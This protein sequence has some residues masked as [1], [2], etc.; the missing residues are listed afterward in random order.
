MSD[1]NA[2]PQEMP[3]ATQGRSGK[4]LLDSRQT[5]K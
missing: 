3:G 2:R 4:V 5:L 1:W